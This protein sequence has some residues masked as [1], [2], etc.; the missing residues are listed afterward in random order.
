MTEP[1]PVYLVHDPR[2]GPPPAPMPGWIW[3]AVS[4]LFV[5]AVCAVLYAVVT[6]IVVV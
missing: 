3:W 4:V 1:T 5:A 6:L 2:L